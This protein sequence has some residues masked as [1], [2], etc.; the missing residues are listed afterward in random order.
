MAVTTAEL[1]KSIARDMR[2][3]PAEGDYYGAD[4]LLVC[5]RC[6]TPKECRVPV[7]GNGALE[8]MGARWEADSSR[9]V[10]RPIM[11]SCREREAADADMAEAAFKADARDA[12]NR[13]ACWDIG[14]CSS[15]T[16]DADD[17]SDPVASGEA[18]AYAEG[19]P[20]TS[21][22]GRGLVFLGGVGCGKTF[23]AACVANLLLDSGAKVRFTSISEL[24]RRASASGYG[25]SSEAV[26]SVKHADL[27]VLDDFGTERQTPSMQEFRYQVVNTLYSEKVPMVVTTNLTRRELMASTG[28]ESDRV[29]SRIVGRC[30]P[31]VMAGADRRKMV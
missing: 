9:A 8:Y 11:C 30:R 22:G 14:R 25:G 29:F 28:T 2:A 12:A 5:G 3:V 16:F 10:I 27:V 19:F 21:D 6:G 23:M 13:A 26:G 1:R 17:G 7:C 24:A 18:R 15:M 4:G 31:V 20:G